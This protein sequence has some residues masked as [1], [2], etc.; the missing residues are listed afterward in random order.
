[1]LRH[2]CHPLIVLARTLKDAFQ[3]AP[4]LWILIEREQFIDNELA[5]DTAAKRNG[6][7]EIR[8][9]KERNGTQFWVQIMAIHHDNRPVHRHIGGA[10][11]KACQAPGDK[12]THACRES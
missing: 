7:D 2:A 9:Q 8:N 1:M 6:P 3:E 12:A 5:W 10:T 4:S 11:E